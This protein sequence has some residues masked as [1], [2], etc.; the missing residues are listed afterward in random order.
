MWL[1]KIFL[2]SSDQLFQFNCIRATKDAPLRYSP[3]GEGGGYEFPERLF[4]FSRPERYFFNRQ[5]LFPKKPMPFFC[6]QDIFCDS[7][8]MQYILYI[9]NYVLQ[10]FFLL[11][12]WSTLHN[13]MTLRI[14]EKKQIP[15]A[16]FISYFSAVSLGKTPYSHSA[17][18]NPGVLDQCMFLGNWPL[19]PRQ[20]NI[21]PYFALWEKC[22]PRGGVGGQ[23]PR[24]MHR[25]GVLM[26]TGEC[27]AGGGGGGGNPAIE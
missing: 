6:M 8:A 20:P 25:S 23:F 24:S 18:L 4:F 3:K 7:F 27:N 10:F 1:R 2:T 26:G 12:F 5:N 19:T 15:S 14:K 21:N 22:W 16:W 11:C 17:S 13:G 9:N